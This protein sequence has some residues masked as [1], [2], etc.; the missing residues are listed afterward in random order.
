MK[1]I[2]FVTGMTG[3]DGPYLANLMFYF[4]SV[5]KIAFSVKNVIAKQIRSIISI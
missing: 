1:K 4:Y 2:A 5:G 3:Q